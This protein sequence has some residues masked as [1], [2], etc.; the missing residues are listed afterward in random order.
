MSLVLQDKLWTQLGSLVSV[1]TAVESLRDSQG[2]FVTS[3]VWLMSLKQNL[4][5]LL[6]RREQLRMTERAMLTT[7]A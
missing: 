5:R 7:V 3:E 2:E 4:F 6:V 1:E